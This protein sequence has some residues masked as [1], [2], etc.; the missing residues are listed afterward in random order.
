MFSLRP[1]LL[2]LLLSLSAVCCWGRI[3]GARRDPCACLPITRR[4]RRRSRSSGAAPTHPHSP[5]SAPALCAAPCTAAPAPPAGQ[6]Q[7]ARL[8][9]QV[10]GAGAGHGHRVR[11]RAADRRA[12]VLPPY[13][14]SCAAASAGWMLLLMGTG[15]DI[16][17]LTGSCLLSPCVPIRSSPQAAPPR[18]QLLLC[19]P[20]LP[21][22]LAAC[23]PP[24]SACSGGPPVLGRALQPCLFGS[25]LTISLAAPSPLL[26]CAVE[27]PEFWQGLQ[28]VRF[29]GLPRLQDS[30]TVIGCAPLLL[31]AAMCLF[32]SSVACR[33]A[34]RLVPVGPAGLEAMPWQLPRS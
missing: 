11:H 1:A 10:R 34:G 28:P 20:H 4:T 2:L 25:C 32:G 14:L 22:C 30:V 33:A 13:C 15:C 19:G 29:G 5:P 16:G 23:R 27:D 6:G 7:A 9:H 21:P 26:C 18:C 31:L 3:P 24:P 17:L 8:G 12:S